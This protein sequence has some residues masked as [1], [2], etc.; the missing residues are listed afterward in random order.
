MNEE[1]MERL[2]EEGICPL[3]SIKSSRRIAETFGLEENRDRIMHVE[4]TLKAMA[5]RTRIRLL[6]LLAH[7][8]MCVCQL[9]AVFETSQPAMSSALRTLEQAGLVRREKRGKWHFYSLTGN[10]FTELL[11]KEAGYER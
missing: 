2:V 11:M 3:E 4:A 9:T 10:A 8:E 1:S 5:D 7:G 6:L